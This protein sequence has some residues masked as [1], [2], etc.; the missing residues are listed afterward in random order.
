MHARKHEPPHRL[1]PW[2]GMG[3]LALLTLGSATVRLHPPPAPADVAAALQGARAAAF[4]DPPPSADVLRQVGRP[5]G[6]RA[7][8]P[9]L[10]RRLPAQVGRS[11]SR[12]G[13]L[14]E[15][16]SHTGPPP[17]P[18]RQLYEAGAAQAVLSGCNVA[19][20]ILWGAG[21]W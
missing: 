17:P 8:R 3:A 7:S 9:P 2:P 13:G 1:H 11:A 5:R 4:S 18:A 16:C 20:L 12:G 6:L 10:P 14:S 19:A 21:V 15:R